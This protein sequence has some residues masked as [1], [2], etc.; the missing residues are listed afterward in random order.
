MLQH[1]RVIDQPCGEWAQGS[2]P[3]GAPDTPHTVPHAPSYPMAPAHTPQLLTQAASGTS[4]TYPPA[5]TYTTATYYCLPD[6]LTFLMWPK[7]HNLKSLEPNKGR[8]EAGGSPGYD[9]PNRRS[10]DL[11]AGKP[12]E[13]PGHVTRQMW[14]GEIQMGENE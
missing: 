3:R 5:P 4:P 1:H 2:G 14:L 12:T 8:P 6:S 7:D 13:T 9:D 11:G 10:G